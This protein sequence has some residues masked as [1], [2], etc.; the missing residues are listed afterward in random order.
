M[1][2]KAGAGQHVKIYVTTLILYS[3]LKAKFHS[4][5]VESIHDGDD[6][7][8]SDDEIVIMVTHNPRGTLTRVGLGG[9]PFPI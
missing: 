6:G 5:T 7:D 2:Q 3:K 9:P 8:D 4:N 1:I